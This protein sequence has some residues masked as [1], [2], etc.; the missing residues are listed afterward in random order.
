MQKVLLVIITLLLFV[1]GTSVYGYLQYLRS[2]D[3]VQY[4]V[5]KQQDEKNI[6][7]LSSAIPVGTHFDSLQSILS[8]IEFYSDDSLLNYTST[9]QG[10]VTVFPKV[11]PLKSKRPYC[12]Y[13]LLFDED[14]KFKYAICNYPCH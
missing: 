1:T 7:L 13:D 4:K 9:N 8:K 5:S 14:K 2:K 12:G 10:A 3:K 11:P 6:E